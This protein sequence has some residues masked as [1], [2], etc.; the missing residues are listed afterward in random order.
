MMAEHL[1]SLGSTGASAL[2]RDAG[3][4]SAWAARVVERL[5]FADAASLRM[6][7]ELAWAALSDAEWPDALARLELR[8]MPPGAAETQAAA[9]LALKMYG[10]RFGIPFVCAA[11]SDTADELLMR[12]RIRLGNDEHVEQ[13]TARDEA[14]RLLRHRLERAVSHGTM[15][16]G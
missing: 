11:W 12:V 16:A 2:L 3:G 8:E 1:N 10:D 6:A 9:Q 4:C 7:Q 13:R 5:P 14:R 15:E